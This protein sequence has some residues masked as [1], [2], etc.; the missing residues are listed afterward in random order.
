M[1]ASVL[2]KRR[3]LEFATC[4]I[5]SELYDSGD[6]QA[7]FL[8][9][10]HTF[11]KA[12]LQTHIGEKSEFNCP[13]CQYFVNLK[14]DTL[15]S[16]PDDFVMNS[17]RGEI[18]S[19]SAES[20]GSCDE[21]QGKLDNFC[22]NCGS[23]LCQTCTDQ[24]KRMRPLRNHKLSTLDEVQKKKCDLTVKKEQFCKK[25]PEEQQKLYCK[26]SKC[27]TPFCATC[28]SEDH[29]NHEI[30][31]LEKAVEEVVA[32]IQGASNELGS[33][34]EDFVRKHDDIQ[35]IQKMI[36][37]QYNQKVKD[38]KESQQKLV[39][40]IQ[41]QFD[42]MHAHMNNLYLTEMNRLSAAV[43]SVDSVT[44]HMTTA[45]D[46]ATR[47][48]TSS[49]A[50]ALL[51]SHRQIQDRLQ[52]LEKSRLPDTSSDQKNDFTFTPKHHL[53]VKQIEKSMN[54]MFDIDWLTDDLEKQRIDKSHCTINITYANWL[55]DDECMIQ[56][57]DSNGQPM[58][59]SDAKVAAS[60]DQ[61][62]S[63]NV[64]DN[65]NG[66]YSFIYQIDHFKGSRYLP[67]VTVNNTSKLKVRKMIL[68]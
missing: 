49:K 25:H 53:A 33:R 47:A 2:A 13:N 35:T 50:L 45:I 6:H 7:K 66:T 61:S 65:A 48:C 37:A 30:V 43:K 11:C 21:V 44:A 42:K 3:K 20:C 29:P 15:D 16:L 32:E 39:D 64:K 68:F 62:G 9:C 18:F 57:L 36:S 26:D 17:K 41:S 63:F 40:L 60:C 12:C 5:F 28:I 14:D 19:L 51:S 1:A 67:Q 31:D 38:M 4:S 52:E 46:F 10:L 24:H 55:C 23:Y 58:S 34:K 54:D 27:Q 8:P 22:H 59:S 56:M